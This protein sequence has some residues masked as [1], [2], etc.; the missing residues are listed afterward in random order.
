[1]FL[2]IVDENTNQGFVREKKFSQTYLLKHFNIS[3]K[4][5]QLCSTLGMKVCVTVLPD[6]KCLM[7]NP[8]SAFDTPALDRVF[9]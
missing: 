8:D 6:L 9:L 7:T 3:I 1:M 2:I 5:Y 4:R